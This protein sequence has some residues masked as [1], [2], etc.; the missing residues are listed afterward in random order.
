MRTMRYTS[1]VLYT[2]GLLVLLG[3]A[4]PVLAQEPPGLAQEQCQKVDDSTEEVLPGVTLTWGSSFLCAG[5]PDEGSYEFTVTVTNHAGSV[6]T[7]TIDD[8]ELVQTTPKPRGQG[9][10]ATGEASGL[11]TTLAP[12]AT[13]SFTVSGTYQLVATDDGEKANLHF[14]ADGTGDA[15]GEP[16][17]LGINAHFRAPGVAAE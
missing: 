10:D 15:G 8:L 3:S 6:E 11:P 2:V 9:P 14:L 1:L 13:D 5:A 17:E 16:F 4:A 12:G 7:V